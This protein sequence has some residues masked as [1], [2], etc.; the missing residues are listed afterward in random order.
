MSYNKN[1][2]LYIPYFYMYTYYTYIYIF[3]ESPIENICYAIAMLGHPHNLMYRVCTYTYL[4]NVR[5]TRL[6]GIGT[7]NKKY[8]VLSH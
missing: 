4:F 1:K 7:Q 2:S 3:N 6:F 5:K 8:S